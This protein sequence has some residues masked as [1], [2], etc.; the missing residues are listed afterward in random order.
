MLFRGLNQVLLQLAV[1]IGVGGKAQ[2]F[3][4]IDDLKAAEGHAAA[5]V[6]SWPGGR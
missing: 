1:G 4:G 6:S 5:Q 2:A 3:A